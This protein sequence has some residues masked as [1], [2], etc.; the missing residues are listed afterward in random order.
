LKWE[1]SVIDLSGQS[2]G[3]Y[4]IVEKLGEGGMATVYRAFDTN[5]E[6]DVAV[7]VIRREAFSEESFESMLKRFDREAKT[8]AKLTHPN[9]VSIIDYGNYEGSPYLVMPYLQGGT[10]KNLVGRP[11]P[12]PEAAKLLM[13]IASALAYAHTQG[14]IHRDVKPGNILITA[15]GEPM[16]TDFGI[17]KILEGKEGQTLTG[18]G[19]GIGTPEYMA[20]EQGMGKEIDARADIYSLGVVFYEMITGRKPYT[21]D[22][23]MAIVFK[24]LNDPL[25]R[26]GGFIAGLSAEVEK[27]IFK[28]MAKAPADRYSDMGEML[29]VLNRLDRATLGSVNSWDHVNEIQKNSPAAPDSLVTMRDQAQSV[30]TQVQ[31]PPEYLQNKPTKL[32]PSSNKGRRSLTSQKP[33]SLKKLWISLACLFVLVGSI[34]TI[35]YFSKTQKPETPTTASSVAGFSPSLGIT[36]ISPTKESTE[37]LVTPIFSVSNQMISPENANQIKQLGVLGKGTINQVGYSPSGDTLAVASSIGIY[38]YNSTDLSQIR[39]IETGSWITSIAFSPD[40]QSLA[41]GSRDNTIKLWRVTDG[42]LLQT[43]SGH[44]DHVVSVAFS[45]DGQSLASGSRDNT[46]KLWRVSDGS[47]LQT[48]SGHTSLV[49]SVAF[50]PDGQ[51]LASGSWDNTIKL[52]RVSNGSL[53]QTLNGHTGLVVSVAFSPDGQ[54]LASGSADNTIKLWRFSDGSLLQSLSGH[55]DG[56][57]SVA[58]SPDGQTLASGSYDNTIKLWRVSD[59]SLLQTLSGHT[60]GVLTM[61]FSPDGQTLASGSYDNT[62][63]LWQV[64]DGSL[65]QTLSGHTSL[66]ASVAY[67]PDG[68]ILASGSYNNTIKLWRISDG[69]LLQTLS[70]HTSLVMRLAFSP[71]GQTV[72]FGLIDN[73]INLWRLSDGSLLQTLSGHTDSVLSVAFSPDGQILASG[74]ADNTIKLWRV[75]DGSLLQS[76]SG[77]TDGVWSV[78]F[79]PDGQTLASGSYDGTI[80]LWRQSDGSL[81]Q[82]LS[83]HT[84]AVTSIAFSPDGLTL[85]SGSYDNSIKLWRLSDGSL[86]QT[87]SGH[88]DYV[89][90]VAFSPDGQI[91]ASG[92]YDN[93]IKLWQVSDGSLLQ[94]LSGHSSGVTCV[95]FSPDGQTL[96]SGS[97]DGTIRLWGV[98]AQ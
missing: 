69:S 97:Y 60:D 27:L 34:I 80:K 15:S 61:A 83:G 66:V 56:V 20:P 94:T 24:H 54:I 89:L 87:F 8:L 75:S 47:L 48:L 13:P 37:V 39:Y 45:P 40:G 95:A 63:K 93:T 74:S 21:A 33:R 36:K 25:P 62:I 29:A 81:L 1:E 79:S 76:L 26:P 65:L 38:F 4:H 23:P 71:D 86:I 72:A 68:Q 16:L 12:W 44:T 84:D 2:I 98:P 96:A 3:K 59:G 92:S 51:T 53:V 90:S 35:L 19:V 55:T 32:K 9:I 14:V 10:L 91:L 6:R 73:T 42:S 41:S 31:R 70:G 17:A 52:W 85:A 28:S 18:T 67:S 64:S 82:T 30:N 22:T 5:L 43:L 88:T 57:W 50:S 77:H 11:L 7:K 58:F 46:I 78:A 49:M